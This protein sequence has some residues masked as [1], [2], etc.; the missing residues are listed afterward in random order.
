MVKCSACGKD[1][2]ENSRF[3]P[4]CGAR[5]PEPV[6]PTPPSGTFEAPP[7]VRGGTQLV[8]PRNPPQSPHIALLGL[9]ITGLPQILFGQVAKGIVFI[10]AAVILFIPTAGL[11]NL[12]LA[13][14]SV[15]DGY[16]IGNKLK[17][18]TPVGKWEFF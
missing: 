13:A 8:Y 15:I 4:T 10:A 2:P 17:R 16:M 6:P 5:A 3:C 1:I 7:V 14:V 11:A 18:G 9:L 12:A